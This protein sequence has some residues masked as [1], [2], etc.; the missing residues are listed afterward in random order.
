MGNPSHSFHY[1]LNAMRILHRRV[2]VLR[3]NKP[4]PL[5]TPFILQKRLY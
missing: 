3:D 5:G 2:T 1:V 4:S